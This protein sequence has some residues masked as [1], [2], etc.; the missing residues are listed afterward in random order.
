MS[1][2]TITSLLTINGVD[3][4]ANVGNRQNKYNFNRKNVQNNWVDGDYKIHTDVPRKKITG[5][6]VLTFKGREALQAF[7]ANIQDTD[8]AI[9]A[10]VD[11]LG[12]MVTFTA[13]IE[14]TAKSTW[15]ADASEVA[16]ITCSVTIEEK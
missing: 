4:T 12:D 16:F 6:V 14:Y 8:N 1:I 11:N 7:A 3:Y 5:S 10:Y 2:S 15:L 13:D 9:I